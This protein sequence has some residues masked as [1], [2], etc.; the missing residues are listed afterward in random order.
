MLCVAAG[1]IAQQPKVLRTYNWQDLMAQHH[2]PN[3]EIVS[4]DGISVLKIRNTNSTPL[5]V[6]LLEI[7]NSSVLSQAHFLSCDIKYENV[8]NAHGNSSSSLHNMVESTRMI[9][10]DMGS[11]K[12]NVWGAGGLEMTRLLPPDASG[13]DVKTNR[14]YSLIAGTSN[15]QP[16]QLPVVLVK[17]THPIRVELKLYLPGTGTIYLRPAELIGSTYSWLSPQKG[18]VI[19]VVAGIGGA[20]IGCFGALIGCLVGLGKG[21]RFVLATTK[22]FIGLGIL[23]MIAGIIA[24]A[25]HLPWPAWSSMLL[26]GFVLTIVFSINLYPIKRRYDELEIRRMTSMDATGR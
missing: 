17:E 7:T 16:C 11:I 25:C 14:S 21:R 1:A 24:A 23:L 9:S 5:E 2:F 6:D 26:M 19:G 10:M 3:S 13:G 18:V 8:E 15:W 4:M 12:Y 20:G 22:M